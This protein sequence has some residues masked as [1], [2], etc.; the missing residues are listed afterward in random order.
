MLKDL[1]NYYV[2][3]NNKFREVINN[4]TQEEFIQVDEKI[5]RSI[6]ELLLHVIPMY[7]V[8]FCDNPLDVYMKTHEE[9]MTLSKDEFIKF[10]KKSDE[11]FANAVEKMVEDPVFFSIWHTD[12]KMTIN[13]LENL[14]AYTDHS[15]YHR[16]QLMSILKYLGKEGIN[17][18]YYYYLV[19]KHSGFTYKE[20]CSL[21]FEKYGIEM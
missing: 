16:G 17:S 6:K 11:K 19:E 7:E 2:W 5:G 21:F 3:A 15:S 8:V 20:I 4:L 18:D 1:G 12:K 13:A 9:L 14:L 10:W